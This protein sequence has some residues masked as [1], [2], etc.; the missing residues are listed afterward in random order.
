MAEGTGI[1]WTET[2]ATL[3][4]EQI[5]KLATLFRM[6]KRPLP[7]PGK[8]RV[9][10]ATFNPWIGCAAASEGCKNCYAEELVTRFPQM[11]G[12]DPDRRLPVWGQ[13]APRRVTSA[14]NWTK[15]RRLNRLALE[16]GVRIKVFCASL[17]DVFEEFSGEVQGR[18]GIGDSLDAA[19]T[20]L[21]KL[22]EECR[23]LDFLLLTKRP[24]NARRMVPASWAK[25]WPDHVWAGTTAENQ[26]RARE[27]LPELLQIPAR[28]RFVSHEPALEEVDFRPWMGDKVLCL[29]CGHRVFAAVVTCQ[30]CGDTRFHSGPGV[31]W[32]ITGGESGDQ[33]RHYDLATPRRILRDGAAGGVPIF[34]KQLGSYPVSGEVADG[35]ARDK[36]PVYYEKDGSGRW[37]V[38]LKD[39]HGGDM[40]EWP[41]DLQ[42]EQH[43]PV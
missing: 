10:G 1:A 37:E 22:I 42:G 16:V 40:E 3:T 18:P 17:A 26:K 7:P 11:V 8:V 12:V 43:F 21:W 15:I 13:K 28:I 27:R 25:E 6:A 24:Q 39:S 2:E 31:Q 36:L 33:A 19:R 4:A 20:A 5:A 38:H 14:Q 41:A 32:I 29:T 35:I 30:R 23:G 9:P 34:V